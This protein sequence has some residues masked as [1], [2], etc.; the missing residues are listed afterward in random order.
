MDGPV[1]GNLRL[2]KEVFTSYKFIETS[3]AISCVK[4][5]FRTNVSESNLI[6][7]TERGF[8]MLVSNST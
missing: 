4:V 1:L 2:R 7:E 3:R 5:D 8:E 6:T